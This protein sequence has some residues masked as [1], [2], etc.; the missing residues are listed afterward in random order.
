MLLGL[1]KSFASLGKL[2]GCSA[3]LNPKRMLDF[4]L[5]ALEALGLDR[6]CPG[7]LR[8]RVSVFN[9]EIQPKNPTA[10]PQPQTLN[11]LR[12]AVAVADFGLGHWGM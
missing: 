9:S 8:C 6:F 2:L 12:A 4:E 1:G 3:A 5:S 7:F 10:R 11:L